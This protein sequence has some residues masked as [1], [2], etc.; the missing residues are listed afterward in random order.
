MQVGEGR[1]GYKA[2]ESR[3]SGWQA[4]MPETTS[5]STQESCR[6]LWPGPTPI[7][8]VLGLPAGW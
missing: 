8:E 2:P 7:W 3:V 6:V 1:A 4:S 5:L